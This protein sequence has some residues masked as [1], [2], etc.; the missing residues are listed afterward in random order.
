MALLR[1]MQLFFA[2]TSTQSADP[3]ERKIE[4]KP[5]KTPYDPRHMIAGIESVED[6]SCEAAF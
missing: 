5:T 6:G 1:S 3:V 2:I 4:F